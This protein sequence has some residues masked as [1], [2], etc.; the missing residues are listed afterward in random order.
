MRERKEFKTDSFGNDERLEVSILYI[1]TRD[2]RYLDTFREDDIE[3]RT[4]LGREFYD[5]AN[6][7][8][9]QNRM[10]EIDINDIYKE[11]DPEDE[12]AL[13]KILSSIRIGADESSY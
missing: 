3:F 10:S 1:L 11:L 13:K 12:K 8:I 2:V 4:A 7:L 5:V 6:K 9:L